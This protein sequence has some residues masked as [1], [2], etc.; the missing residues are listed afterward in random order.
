MEQPPV[1]CHLIAQRV[2][3]VR[4]CHTAVSIESP[5]GQLG[6]ALA[7]SSRTVP[8]P[9]SPLRPGATHPSRPAPH[10]GHHRPRARHPPAGH[11]GTL[12]PLDD[13]DHLGHVQP[14]RSNAPRRSCRDHR[15]PGSLTTQSFGFYALKPVSVLDRT[16]AAHVSVV[17]GRST[18]AWSAGGMGVPLIARRSS[19]GGVW[20][21]VPVPVM[22]AVWLAAACGV[23]LRI[24]WRA[25]RFHSDWP[26]RRITGIAVTLAGRTDWP[27]SGP[28]AWS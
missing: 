22:F 4:N 21:S 11:T 10:L 5:D 12:R 20:M 26:W 28:M 3:V 17:L 24:L 2:A 19:G 8:P 18:V 27:T 14:R 9:S 25:E 15:K 16:P 1:E 23:V 6:Q 13:L 7:E